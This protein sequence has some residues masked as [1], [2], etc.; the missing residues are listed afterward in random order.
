MYEFG[1]FIEQECRFAAVRTE[2]GEVAKRILDKAAELQL[3]LTKKDLQIQRTQREM[4]I[5]AKFEVPI[6]LKVTTYQY[7]FQRTER[8]PLF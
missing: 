6:D 2:N 1:D 4:I 8:A 7:K 3:P 5:S